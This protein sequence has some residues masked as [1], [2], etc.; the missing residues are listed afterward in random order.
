MSHDITEALDWR[1]KPV[2]CKSCSHLDLNQRGLG[3]GLGMP[4]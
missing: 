2:N 4:A 3:A 1:G